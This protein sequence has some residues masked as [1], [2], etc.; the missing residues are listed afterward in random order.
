MHCVKRSNRLHRKRSA[1]ASQDWIRYRN[2]EASPFESSQRPYGS[3]FLI[4]R[5][6]RSRSCVQNRSGGFSD[7][8]GGR[9][10]P[11]SCADRLECVRVTFQQCGN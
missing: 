3:F 1:D 9:D 5:Q 8:E 7:R 4:S 11:S 10:L 6:P 2:Q